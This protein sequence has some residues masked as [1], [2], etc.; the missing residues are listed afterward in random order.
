VKSS[1]KEEKNNLR[2]ID[3]LSIWWTK[4]QKLTPELK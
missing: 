2:A 3:L 1:K 4:N